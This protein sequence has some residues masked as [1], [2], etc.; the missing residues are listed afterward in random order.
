MLKRHDLFI[1]FSL[2]QKFI[3]FV[4]VSDKINQTICLFYENTIVSFI[5]LENNIVNK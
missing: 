2:F 5:D 1:F 4:I 3:N